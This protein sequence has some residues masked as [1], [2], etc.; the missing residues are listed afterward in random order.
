[1][2][3]RKGTLTTSPGPTLTVAL[4][5]ELSVMSDTAARSSAMRRGSALGEPGCGEYRRVRG[6]EYVAKVL[7]ACDPMDI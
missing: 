2:K 6:E 1:L 5:R 7:R 3:Q 4:S